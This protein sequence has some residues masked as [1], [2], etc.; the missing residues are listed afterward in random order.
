M[1]EHHRLF[2]ARKLGASGRSLP[3]S[4]ILTLRL[5]IRFARE[6]ATKV[7]TTARKL[8]TKNMDPR[9]PLF[10]S[11]F[12]RKKNAIHDLENTHLASY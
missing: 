9:R 7:V 2:L 8:H 3:G 10:M 11:N 1:G 4:L 5:P 6:D 12:H